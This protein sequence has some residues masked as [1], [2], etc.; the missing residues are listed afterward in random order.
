MNFLLVI[1]SVE[2]VEILLKEIS[3]LS[4]TVDGVLHFSRDQRQNDQAG[5]PHLEK[6][7]DVIKRVV[8]LLDNQFKENRIKIELQLSEDSRSFLIEADKMVQVFMNLLLNSCESMTQGGRIQLSSEIID[9]EVVVKFIDNGP[10]IAPQERNKIFKPFYSSNVD[11]TGLGLTISSRIV[12]SC[13]GNITLDES[14]QAGAC[15]VV[16]LPCE[17]SN[18]TSDLKPV[19]E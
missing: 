3:R 16:S 11:G 17:Y 10:G 6:L 4:S 14:R 12:E 1:K 15:F 19:Y 18:Q 7:E 2:F 5:L 13:G 8:S 9:N